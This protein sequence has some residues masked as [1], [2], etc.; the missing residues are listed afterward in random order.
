MLF[1]FCVAP[2]RGRIFSRGFWSVLLVVF[3][4]AAAPSAQAQS[5]AR[6]EGPSVAARA[7]AVDQARALARA[8]VAKHN[9]PGLSVSVGVDGD[10]VWA[11]GFGWANLE[12]RVPVTPLSRF[13]VGS[14]AKSLT[15]VAMGQLYQAGRVDLDAPV[16]KYVPSFPK[17]RWPV[18][19]REL[20]AHT[21][22]IRDYRGDEFLNSK[23]YDNILDGLK[24]FENDPLVFKPGTQYLYTS[25]GWNLVGAVVQ[26][27]AH[28]PYLD[29]M[30]THVFAP[31][32]MRH[33]VPDDVA[34]VVPHRTA[35]YVHDKQGRLRNAPYVDNS[36]KWPSGG[37]LSTPDDLVRFGFALLD[38]KLLKPATRKLLWSPVY[39][40]SG[41]PIGR[42]LDWKLGT[43][44]QGRH[45]VGHM[46][47]SV[48]GRTVFRI[49]PRQHMVIAAT[50]NL[51][52]A[53]GLSAFADQLGNLFAPKSP[54]NA[55]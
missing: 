40:T 1:S 52:D 11:Q 38:G 43:D 5:V 46:G 33:T 34:R 41:K 19:V 8:L 53:D 47:G 39:L 29:Y 16:Q 30:R 49:Y 17:K 4:L 25:Y 55:K 14:V 18:T 48:G 23:H 37:F 20:M 28:E 27:V 26:S 2:Y 54:S 24:I 32:G 50:T 36:Y 42:G 6:V 15:S 12:E 31:A 22:G 45:H 44:A 9:L 3:F 13:R 35:Y 10:V 51:S 7:H 21:A